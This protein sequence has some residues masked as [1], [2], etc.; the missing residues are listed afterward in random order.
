MP[1][2]G[3]LHTNEPLA[4]GKSEVAGNPCG[5]QE[6]SRVLVRA[7]ADVVERV[8]EP[9]VGLEH[10]QA[11]GTPPRVRASKIEKSLGL[12]RPDVDRTGGKVP[13]QELSVPLRIVLEHIASGR[14]HLLKNPQ[15]LFRRPLCRHALSQ[16]ITTA[17]L[18]C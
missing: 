13:L 3:F 1:A 18:F 2:G 7:N 16:A 12:V 9:E 6:L 11:K 14:L 10:R 8:E 15:T 17:E 4:R 5:L